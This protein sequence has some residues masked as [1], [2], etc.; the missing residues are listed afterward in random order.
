MKELAPLRQGEVNAANVQRI[1][2]EWLAIFGNNLYH[3]IHAKSALPDILKL[4]RNILNTAS[5]DNGRIL[6]A[7][8][9]PWRRIIIED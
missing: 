8:G 7:R 1:F 6:T 2:T 4:P 9:P 3:A 5:T